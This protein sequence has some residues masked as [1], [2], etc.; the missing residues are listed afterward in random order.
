MEKLIFATNNANKVEEVKMVLNN[1]FEILSLRDAGIDV[2]IPEPYNTLEGNASEKS[3]TIYRLINKNCFSEDT[4]LEVF[5]LDGEPG[6]KSAR[7][8]G[9]D[10][11]F[12]DNIDKLLF[13]LG[14]TPD[15]KAQFRTIISLVID[16]NETLFEGVCKGEIIKDRRG[17]AGFGYDP[18]FIPE[19]SELTFAE[20][21]KVAKNQFSHRRKAMEKL[22]SFLQECEKQ[23]T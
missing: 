4:G 17:T 14:N 20:M 13:K 5:S 9:E 18:V 15:R 19:G 3:F 6:V 12:T 11:S 8:A 2:D 21:G 22:I 1:R 10:N 7:Y 23:R 16:G